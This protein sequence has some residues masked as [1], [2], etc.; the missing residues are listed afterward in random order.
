MRLVQSVLCEQHFLIK[1]TEVLLDWSLI[2]AGSAPTMQLLSE[3]PWITPGGKGVLEGVCLSAKPPQNFHMS[4]EQLSQTSQK[5]PPAWQRPRMCLCPVAAVGSDA[6]F[7]PAGKAA[8]QPSRN[9]FQTS[10]QQRATNVFWPK[11]S[12]GV[13]SA[14]QNAPKQAQATPKATWMAPSGSCPGA[15]AVP[16]PK[17]RVCIP[18]EC[19]PGEEFTAPAATAQRDFALV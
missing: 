2:A 9:E 6:T 4:H 10:P 13:G 8:W 18:R 5:V 12:F 15:K 19:R 14:P 3:H 1:C 11:M 7:V 17:G 16:T